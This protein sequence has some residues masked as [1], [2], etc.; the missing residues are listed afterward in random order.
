[1]TGARPAHRNQWI[2]SLILGFLVFAVGTPAMAI[3]F[4]DGRLQIHGFYEA[5]LSYGWEDFDADK[6]INQFGF[7]HVL[8]VEVEA[9]LLPDGWGPFDLVSSFARVEVKFDCVYIRGCYVTP[10]A[11]SWGTRPK[12]IA[13]RISDGR[14]DGVA[15]SQW[16]VPDTRTY[17]FHDETQLS[18]GLF[19]ASPNMSR[20]WT[21]TVFGSQ[22]VALFGASV[23]P[24]GT[25]DLFE[26]PGDD[27]GF[28]A[29]NPMFG[30]KSTT[31]KGT[32][33][34]LG[35]FS[36]TDF[37]L[38]YTCKDQMNPRGILTDSPNP[39]QI[40]DGNSQI[41][42]TLAAGLGGPG[43]NNLPFRPP[44]EI[45]NNVGGANFQSRGL[46][47]PSPGYR[48][49]LQDEKNDGLDQ[50]FHIDSIMWNRGAS[51]QDEGELREFYFDVEMADSRLWLRLGKQTIV[52]G[53]TELF[54]N[55]DQWNPVDIAIGPL[56]GLEES[57]IA[58][59]AARGVWSFYE[60][61]PLEDVR[62]EAAMIYDDFEPTDLGICGEPFVPRAAC[63]VGT[64]TVAHGW[65][66][67]GV[68]GRE[69][70]PEP[71]DDAHGIE[72]G[73]RVEFRYDR[74]SFAVSDF[75][76]FTDTPYAD[77]IFQYEHN[78]D[79]RTGR[80]RVAGA[81]GSCTTGAENA[82]LTGNTAPGVGGNVGTNFSGN[83]Q[84]FDVVCAATVGVTVLDPSSC[85][86]SLFGST[87]LVQGFPLSQIFSEVL[88]GQSG[89]GGTGGPIVTNGAFFADNTGSF[90]LAT[91]TALD[92]LS[93]QLA[94]SG[95]LPPRP[96]ALAGG[97]NRYRFIPDAT[98]AIGVSPCNPAN[99]N[100]PFGG[101]AASP[102]V[103]LNADPMD[104]PGGLAIAGA[105][106]LASYTTAEQQALW[107][108]GPFYGTSCDNPGLDF[109]NAEGGALLQSFPFFEG[110]AGN[111]HWNT[112]DV[113]AAQP[114]TTGF[115]GGTPC[116]R[117]ENGTTYILPGCR[118][119]GQAGYNVNQD[120]STGGLLHPFTG[121]QFSSEMAAASWN[122][123]ILAT[124]F[125]AVADTPSLGVFDP[126]KPFELGRCSFA[127]PQYCAFVAGLAGQSGVTRS[128]VRAGGNGR[129]GRRDFVWHTG[130]EVS[131]RFKK[132]NVFGFAMDFAEDITKSS[133]GVEFTWVNDTPFTNNGAPNSLDFAD[134]YNL[135]ISID[136]PT[137]INFLNSNRTFF[138]NTQLFFSYIDGYQKDYTANGPFTFLWLVSMN[139]GYFQDRLLVGA[140]VVWDFASSSGAFLPT[141]QYRFS[142]NFSATVGAGVF[143]G[144]L[145][146]K[147]MGIDRLSSISSKRTG[148]NIYVENGIS[149]ARDLDN[150]FF[151]LRYTF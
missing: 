22:L 142:E 73:G 18:S 124:L 28:V 35:G 146:R 70:P 122:F 11:H 7:L 67:I 117:Y 14:R 47:Y 31:R 51:Q 32:S 151:R 95:A 15:G 109:L 64:G 34:T 76:G 24:N 80:P 74:F 71:W 59:W 69:L 78:V 82:C 85:V 145:Q 6:Q 130:G 133:V 57:R 54:R 89:F 121:Q 138:I 103:P 2:R 66:G 107:G 30:C 36:N 123:M 150:F 25:D 58:Q 83:R 61:G 48:K 75:Y 113:S 53:K 115:N 3:E 87:A 94:A 112:T 43:R 62:V 92:G 63:F 17:D 27:A 105:G 8:N 139:T 4:W 50:Y 118:G 65:S 131:L 16:S 84:L 127:N 98:A 114:G 56:A 126:N 147:K 5:R 81:T 97:M 140:N 93:N 79:P 77:L 108:C 12:R 21:E 1:M 55:Q 132:R 135:T 111:P 86:Y 68:A 90:T 134:T 52:W 33:D 46:F 143:T 129:Y 72:Y 88:G 136:R 9:D 42:P 40:A 60:V 101:G 23:G 149:P 91:R 29:L 44:T 137:F 19:Y 13:E 144:G 125:G 141:A 106:G 99:P 100:C 119:P 39:F 45:A 102:L 104:N 96:G 128:T 26:S 120:G 20:Q 116:L 110:T 37:Y 49:Y 10:M 148:D 38:N 41:S